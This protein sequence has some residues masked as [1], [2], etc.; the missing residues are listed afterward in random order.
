[1]YIFKITYSQT[2]VSTYLFPLRQ[3]FTTLD[4]SMF[5]I[6][7]TALVK[8]KHKNCSQAAIPCL[9]DDPNILVKVQRTPTRAA[10]EF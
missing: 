7:Y 3:T 9:R 8:S 10:S 1:M 2:I 6:V 5:I 4:I